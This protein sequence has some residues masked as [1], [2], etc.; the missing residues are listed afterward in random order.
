MEY[1]LVLVTCRDEKEA[2]RI[3][4]RLLESRQAACV[5]MIPGMTSLFHWQGR[6]DR[7][8]EVLLMIK[9][10]VDLF[11]ALRRTVRESHSYETPEIIAVP[12]AE[13]DADYLNWVKQ[14]T[15]DGLR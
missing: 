10:R 1:Y 2:E 5:N 6:M 8:Q 7:A 15:P 13:G 9:T 3:A 12:V 4:A 11:E 14:E